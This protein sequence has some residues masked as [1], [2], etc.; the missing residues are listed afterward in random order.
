MPAAA[1][2]VRRRREV[3]RVEGFSDAAFAFAVTLLVVSLEVPH[4][5]TD[6]MATLSGAPAFA[7]CFALLVVIWHHHYVF[8][9]RYGLEDN[10]TI[11]L[12]ALLLFVVLL[13]VYP[14]KFLFLFLTEAFFGMG[15][16]E[17][18][19][20]LSAVDLDMVSLMTIYGAGV[21]AVYSIFILMYLHAWRRRDA[22]ELDLLERHDTVSSIQHFVIYVAI[23]FASIGI[24]QLGG[25][26][27]I[28]GIIYG[29]IGPAA[30]IHGAWRG[31]KRRS[32]TSADPGEF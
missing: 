24:V 12:N 9:R 19:A 26:G 28:S 1:E 16:P 31:R 27:F 7:I 15:G 21:A 5:F 22:L 30:A 17:G 8:F 10:P 32:M 25:S 13:Y 18:D 6:L 29:L 4:S 3:S 11:A 20:M 23:A 14:L 2:R